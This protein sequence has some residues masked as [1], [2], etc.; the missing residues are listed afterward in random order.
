MFKL[1]NVK[2]PKAYLF[3]LVPLACVISQWAERI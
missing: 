1:A 3:L 2:I